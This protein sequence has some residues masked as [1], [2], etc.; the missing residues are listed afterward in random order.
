MHCEVGSVRSIS[1]ESRLQYLARVVAWR[2]QSGAASMEFPRVVLVLLLGGHTPRVGEPLV[3]PRCSG[4]HGE[5]ENLVPRCATE[6]L[7]TKRIESQ[8][9]RLSIRT[10]SSE[11]R[12]HQR[13]CQKKDEAASVRNNVHVYFV[14]DVDKKTTWNRRAQECLPEG[15][16]GETCTR[17]STAR[18][19]ACTPC[20][21]RSLHRSFAFL[22]RSLW[23]RSRYR[24]RTNPMT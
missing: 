1:K 2:W 5:Q 19:A 3:A 14:L 17:R 10:G 22:G 20:I 8:G 23:K 4:V 7:Q 15:H 9:S 11:R 21:C 16:L 12:L 13:G 24:K 6:T 18:H